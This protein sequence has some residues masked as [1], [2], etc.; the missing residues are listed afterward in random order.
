MRE[1]RIESNDAGQR[2]DKFVTKSIKK[3]PKSL[4]YKYIRLKRIKLNGKRCEPS[5]M[6][7]EGDLISFYINDE[8]FEA[9]PLTLDFLDA[10]D[11]LKIVYEDEN[12]LLID[13]PPGLVVHQ[14][15]RKGADT[16]VHSLKRYLY[17]KGEYL[18]EKENGF[19]PAFCNRIDRNTGG[20]VMAAKNAAA[21]RIL[22]EKIRERE[23][24]KYYL[25]LTEG[26]PDRK[27]ETLIHYLEKDS[28][29]NKAMIQ[30]HKTQKNKEIVTRYRVLRSDA[31]H[32]LMEVELLTG[33]SHQ[34]RAQLA[35]IGYP[36]AGDT[37]Y[38]GKEKR[39][40]YPLYSYKLRFGFQTDAGILNY[41]NGKSFQVDQVWFENEIIETG[42]GF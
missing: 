19:T 7:A 30:L 22:N 17:Q 34:I 37:K 11:D 20:I 23:I 21:L 32:S 18:P 27:Q 16:L 24:Q 25:C 31:A 38:G 42:K 13:K 6:L 15:M 36:L 33:R 40:Y 14:D 8:F 29:K 35:Y 1:F 28:A 5:T 39:K 2:I 41:L 9:E 12:I 10:S 3:L 4:L 26:V